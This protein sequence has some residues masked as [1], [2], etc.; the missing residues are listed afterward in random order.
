MNLFSPSGYA[1]PF[2]LSEDRQPEITLGYGRQVN[3]YTGQEFFH[4][5]IDFKVRPGTWLKALASGVVSGIASEMQRGFYLTVLYKNYAAGGQGSYEVIYSQIKESLC[6][7]GGNVVAGDNIA[8]SDDTLHVEVRFDGEEIN[9]IEF[10]TMI[11]D[12]TLMESQ[13]KMT[14][15]NPEIAVME[16]DVHTPYDAHRAEIEAM[17]Q[18]YMKDY[19]CDILKGSYRVP[20][21]TNEHIRSLLDE[22]RKD[23]IYYQHVPSAMNPLGIG[24]MSLPFLGNLYTVLLEDFL[25]YMAMRHGVF[26]SYLSEADKKKLLT[27]P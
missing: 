16:M 19:F 13:K 18:K 15:S 27:G 17:Q 26:L 12:N 10:L 2:E 14:G 7:F 25:N 5:G 20:D 9:P 11:R 23:G 6:S 24:S 1:M 21:L 22:G 4:H 3:P 8:V